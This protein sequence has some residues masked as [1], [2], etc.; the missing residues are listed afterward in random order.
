MMQ[1]SVRREMI[2]GIL[3]YVATPRTEWMQ[4][5][6]AQVVLNGSQAHWTRETEE[7]LDAS[8]AAGVRAYYDVLC[9][10]LEDMVYLIRGK[11]SKNARVKIGAL[12]VLD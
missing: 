4:K 8:G 3:D 9:N 2:K 6:P 10:Q 7:Y 5:W 1:L 11:L 12:A